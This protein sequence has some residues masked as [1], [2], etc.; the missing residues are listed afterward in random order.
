[1]N[2]FFTII[3]PTYNQGPFIQAA[4]DS[5]LNQQADLEIRVYDAV[6]TD[7]TPAILTQYR[8]RLTWMREKD[9]GMTDAI[10]KGIRAARGQVIAWLNSDDMYLPHALEHVRAAFT[11][12]A[13]LDFLYGDALEINREGRYIAPNVFTEDCCRERYLYSHN[14][15][16]QPTVFF[17]RRV[18]E[19]IGLLRED[20]RWT[21]D[22]EWFARFYLHGMKGR[23]LPYF[24]AANRDYA[25]TLTNSGGAAR[26]REM[27][28][29]HRLRPGRPL[30]LR[31]AYWIYTLEALIKGANARQAKLPE[32]ALRARLLRH[33][34]QR[35][36][37]RFVPLVNPRSRDD[38]LARFQRD[39]LPHG[40]VIQ[41][42]W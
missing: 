37:R 22:Y 11:T 1:M 14:Y 12:D 31:R 35:A 21:M 9:K 4:L 30:P 32:Q 17:H 7:E 23:R 6:S 10:N 34:A 42:L 3:M 40:D 20:L 28:S 18:P 26:Y 27:M 16:C 13:G 38:I 24:L 25:D 19:T 2:P 39:I 36:G 41:D 8:D 29:I 5:I 15:M 33:F